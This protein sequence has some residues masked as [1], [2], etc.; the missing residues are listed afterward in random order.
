MRLA[1]RQGSDFH[2]LD[3]LLELCPQPGIVLV[4]VVLRGVSRGRG[5]QIRPLR[6]GREDHQ[7]AVLLAGELAAIRHHPLAGLQIERLEVHGHPP[8]TACWLAAS[9]SPLRATYQL[10]DY[11]STSR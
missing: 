9:P 2:H 1:S 5:D 6:D 3:E 7:L 4:S 11:L 10:V 8:F